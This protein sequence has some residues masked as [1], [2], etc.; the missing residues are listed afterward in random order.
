[1]L[2]VKCGLQDHL[3]TRDADKLRH[4]ADALGKVSCAYLLSEHAGDLTSSRFVDFARRCDALGIAVLRSQDDLG[5]WL[6][7]DAE[8]AVRSESQSE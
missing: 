2:E 3:T 5:R 7:P 4:A 6:H 1:M 8:M